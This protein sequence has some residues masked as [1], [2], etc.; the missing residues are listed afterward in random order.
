V[1]N[2]ALGTDLLIC[3]WPGSTAMLEV[4]NELDHGV[5]ALPHGS[6]VILLNNHTWQEV[7][8]QT[9]LATTIQRLEISHVK[10][11]PRDRNA[12][13]TA[14]DVATLRAA[15]ILHDTHWNGNFPAESSPIE[16]EGILPQY[17]AAAEMSAY[18]LSQSDMLRM[19]AA[20]LEVQ[21]NVRYLLES[22]C[23]PDINILSEKLTYL[24]QTRFENRSELPIGAA[25]NSASFA[26]KVIA[27]TAVQPRSLFAYARLGEQCE[28]VV[29]DAAAFAEQGEVIN[30]FMLQA[31]CASVSQVLLGY[32]DLPKSLDQVL[33][34]LVNP[35]PEDRMVKRVW[36]AGNSRCKLITLAPRIISAVPKSS[37]SQSPPLETKSVEAV[38]KIT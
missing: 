25:I 19:D 38:S 20:V 23:C 17:R 1:E 4:L 15:V 3:G 2:K 6:R 31:R 33:N 36:N 30:F 16:K 18:S 22:S 37:Q 12:L 29:Q 27:Q 26:A 35:D 11:D 5:E 32:Y 24:G 21:L 8:S 34:I 28:I 9:A 10:C 14:L 13:S 7:S